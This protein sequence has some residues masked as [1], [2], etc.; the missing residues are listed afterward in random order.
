MF[1]ARTISFSRSL[2]SGF[3][4]MGLIGALIAAKPVL[5]QEADV[6][7]PLPL[8]QNGWTEATV[9]ADQGDNY[10]DFLDQKFYGA[11]AMTADGYSYWYA[12]FH[13]LESAR[14][15]TLA[16]CED[17]SP[18]EGL[19]CEIAAFLVPA[20]IPEGFVQGLS[21][22]AHEEFKEFMTYGSE[23]SF[24]VSAN[25]SYAYTWDYGSS[26]EAD[27]EAIKLCNESAEEKAD[28]VI[29]QPAG[30]VLYDFRDVVGGGGSSEQL[31]QRPTKK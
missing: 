16:W 17:D 26:F 19:P 2:Q 23:K 12:G 22:T 10:L 30:C 9:V 28:W 24:A 4:F 6:I 18:A 8:F 15:A 31:L 13:D 7:A 20:E 29:G 21:A 14:I 27:R 1:N 3:M 5:A 25:G 11:F